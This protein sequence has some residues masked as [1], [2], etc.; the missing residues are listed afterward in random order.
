MFKI[1]RAVILLII[2]AA[3]MGLCCAQSNDQWLDYYTTST[4]VIDL[5]IDADTLWVL[6]YDRLVKLST[7]S[8][9]IATYD[10]S[11]SPLP[12]EFWGDIECDTEGNKWINTGADGVLKFDG[13][14][15]TI[16]DT[17]NSGLPTNNIFCITLD[18]TGN[19]WVGTTDGL[20]IYDGTTWTV[21]DTSN[22]ELQRNDIWWLDV[23]GN[24]NGWLV[25][26]EPG[27]G[28]PGD[29]PGFYSFLSIYT[30]DS[31]II[32]DD[33]N[34][35]L[36]N[37][38]GNMIGGFV[39]DDTANAMW[40][41]FMHF[42]LV[43]ITDNNWTLEFEDDTGPTRQFT[44]MVRDHSGVFWLG[45]AYNGLIRFD[46]LGWTSY[47]SSNSGLTN[48]VI[49]SLAVDAHNNL[50][51]GTSTG[52]TVYNEAGVTVGIKSDDRG[53]LPASIK[54]FPAYPNP[55]NP[56]T[57]IQYELPQRSDIQITIYDLLGKEVTTLVSEIQEAGYKTAQWNATNVPSGMYFY[58]IRAGEFVQ[59][60]KM[61]L[62]K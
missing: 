28:L 31:L 8:G 10:S 2:I 22:S 9:E 20:A 36:R 6:C 18:S 11:N 55:F 47:T 23:D 42:G 54:L 50:W 49:K 51:I 15:W 61:I 37:N 59:T 1:N 16:Y 25:T 21:F 33:L 13:R 46:T 17:S 26:L 7:H 34:A 4:A 39:W 57:T 48:N 44:C 27:H 45:T 43:R 14:A 24:G 19:V 3:T 5:E 29:G 52:I 40:I 53:Q 56:I 38:G 41:C 58:Q 12:N 35:T 32:Y 62:M 30:G 60:K